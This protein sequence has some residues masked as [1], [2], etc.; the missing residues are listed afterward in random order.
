MGGASPSPRPVLLVTGSTGYL[1][2]NFV[3]AVSGQGNYRI[4]TLD[5]DKTCSS[6]LFENLSSISRYDH[7]DLLH[8]ELDLGHVEVLVH[9]A[10]ARS[11]RGTEEIAES[12]SFTQRV[13]TLAA[14]H[15]VPAIVNISSQ[16]VY[17]TKRLPLW[18]E[19]LPP[20]PET[21]YAQAKYASELF[22]R[23]CQSF[24]RQTCC[25]S[26]RMATLSGGQS[27]MDRNEMIATM[28][29]RVMDGQ[30]IRIQGGQQILTRLDVRDAAKSLLCLL[31]IE[32]TRW[33]PVYNVD[34]PQQV[35]ICEIAEKIIEIMSN[36]FKTNKAEIV[37]ID[38]NIPTQFGMNTC[39]FNGDT[40]WKAEFCIED[41]INGVIEFS[42]SCEE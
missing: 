26:L 28:V 5:R 32:P 17:G 18:S 4:W 22:L 39:L 19:D 10:F 36:R 30:D 13:C 8:G 23:S 37:I 2:R 25:T 42:Q 35:N 20:A 1:G 15:Q 21:P 14:Q 27:G 9:C 7:D 16:S 31:S 24:N 41:T 40:D 6:G 12:L 33:K 11:Y 38:A 29:K 3:Q 34:S